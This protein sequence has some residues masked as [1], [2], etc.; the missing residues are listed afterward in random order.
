MTEW[1]KIKNRKPTP[2]F[3][4]RDRQHKREYVD[5]MERIIWV[6]AKT[7]ACQVEYPMENGSMDRDD[8]VVVGNLVRGGQRLE[9]RG[10]GNF[11]AIQGC[12]RIEGIS[13]VLSHDKEK[14][15][16][17]IVRRAFEIEAQQPTYQPCPLF[18]PEINEIKKWDKFIPEDDMHQPYV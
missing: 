18:G 16:R 13:D 17:E 8:M 6:I 5:T 10:R 2:L 9:V 15:V 7:C 4:F 14:E 12:G 3:G 1:Q 11:W